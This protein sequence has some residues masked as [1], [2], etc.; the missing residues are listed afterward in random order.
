MKRHVLSRLGDKEWRTHK[1]RAAHHDLGHAVAV[2]V[3]HGDAARRALAHAFDRVAHPARVA[4]VVEAEQPS[5]APRRQHLGHAVA[6]EV[7]GGDVVERQRQRV[8]GRRT[9][10]PQA[11]AVE[12]AGRDH[13]PTLRLVGREDH[14]RYVAA[15]D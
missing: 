2:E 11:R 8:L 7:A 13:R 9:K 10:R 6:V 4:L 1:H 14:V 15:V 3:A 12:A 5:V